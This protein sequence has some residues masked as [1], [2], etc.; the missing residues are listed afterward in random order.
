MTDPAEATGGE[1]WA[2]AAGGTADQ[3][4]R[5]LAQA[6]DDGVVQFDAEGDVTAVND[7]LLDLTTYSRETLLGER[8]SLLVGED[9][10]R[11]IGLSLSTQPATEEPETFEMPVYTADDDRIPCEIRMLPLAVDGES[12]GGICLVHLVGDAADGS[13]ADHASRDTAGRGVEPNLSRLI[14]NVPGMVYRCRN[15]RGWPMEFVSDASTELTGYDPAAIRSGRVEYGTD[16]VHEDDREDLWEAIQSTVTDREPF[17]ETYRIVTAGGETRWVRDHGRGMFDDGELTGIEG[18]ISDITEHKRTE[19]RLQEEREMFAAGPTVVFRWEPDEQAG[20]PVEYVSP[21]VETAFGYTP[22]EL[23]SEEM[24]YADLIVDEDLD[25]IRETIEDSVDDTVEQFSHDP[26]RIETADGDVRWVTDTTKII[27]DDDG[28]IT[29]FLGYLVD[30]TE[31][32]ER[33]RELEQYKAIVE[34]INDGVYVVDEDG[35]FTMVNDTYTE[36]LGYD[37]EELLG[38]HVSMVV[39]EETVAAAQ[40]TESALREDGAD[41]PTIDAQLK[42]AD[43]ERIPSEARFALLRGPDG[44]ERRVGVARD[45]SDRKEYERK[46]ER[47]NERLEQFA[48]AVSHDLQEPLRMVSSYLR[49]LDERYGDTFDEEGREFLAFAVDGADRMRDMV[50]GL[51]EYSR[52]ETRGDPFEPVDLAAVVDD[53]RDDLH[54]A[55]EESGADITVG[56]LPT[57]EGDADQLRQVFQNLVENAIEYSGDDP[58]QIHLDAER[59]GEAWV[60][61]VQDDGLGLDPEHADRIFEM[62]ERH[63]TEEESGTGIGLALCERIVD[64]HGGEIWVE[65]APGKGATFSLTLPATER[66][67]Q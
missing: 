50:E 43:G 60:V 65:S 66:E 9:G 6:I 49:L 13:A 40:R 16:I 15:E 36:M 12:R 30:I 38:E 59:D 61:S 58:P 33:E 14:D 24:A 7:A 51:L 28:T 46:L 22:E 2:D 29:N 5:T 35:R 63:H 53:V 21:N 67:S 54:V 4:Y 31:R 62:F 42:T 32:T 44:E 17:S 18:I 25:R 47:S 39:D 23:T 19:R 3:R 37:R 11:R 64:R 20:W 48:H 8:I 56:T 27:R 52:V 1:F 26:Y 55:I 57:V 45:V 10:W 41:V 34:T